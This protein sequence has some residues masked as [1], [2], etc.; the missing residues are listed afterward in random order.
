MSN[1]LTAQYCEDTY[2][3]YEFDTTSKTAA[4]KYITIWIDGVPA[5]VTSFANDNFKQVNA[6]NLR[7]GSDDCDVYIYLIKFYK[8]S[9]TFDEHLINFIM[10]APNA[11]EMMARFNRN[12]ITEQ[13]SNNNTYI[14]P[15]LLAEK[16]P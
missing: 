15:Y 3:E 6:K 14:S 11:T 4:N 16:N 9:L 10:D 2:I 5:G 12:D 8:K 7:I 13:D 1:S